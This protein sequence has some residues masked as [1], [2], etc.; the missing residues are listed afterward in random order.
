M[1]IMGKDEKVLLQDAAKVDIISTISKEKLEQHKGTLYL[2]NQRLLMEAVTGFISKQTSVALDIPLVN[3]QNVNVQG[4]IGKKLVV[5]ANV[6]GMD[7]T[8]STDKS[9]SRGGMDYSSS[10]GPIERKVAGGVSMA[11]SS[12]LMRIEV[13]VNNPQG[14]A[15][16]ILHVVQETR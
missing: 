1:V 16:Q 5:E 8:M 7:V 14:W 4:L 2:T 9:A 3:I 11:K 6:A 13:S 15:S 12:N 10:G